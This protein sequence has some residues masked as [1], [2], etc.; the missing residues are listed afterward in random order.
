MLVL[1]SAVSIVGNSPPDDKVGRNWAGEQSKRRISIEKDIG[2]RPT[3]ACP[4]FNSS[5]AES[6][7]PP[8]ATGA[9]FLPLRFTRCAVGIIRWSLLWRARIGLRPE[10]R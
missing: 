3:T 1:V 10:F 4:H 2:E 6:A 7:L 9:F 5:S 8:A